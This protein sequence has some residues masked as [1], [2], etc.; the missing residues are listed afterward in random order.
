[1]SKRNFL[2]IIIFALLLIHVY[3]FLNGIGYSKNINEIEKYKK[4]YSVKS[5]RLLEDTFEVTF[6]YEKEYVTIEGVSFYKIKKTAKNKII[7]F[8]NDVEKP[9]L[10][11]ISQSSNLYTIDFIFSQN[12][13]VIK[14]SEW[15]KSNRLIYG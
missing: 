7:N 4:A 12:E 11:I 15:L 2:L 14:F 6:L 13:Q 1:M 3:F 8:F 10:L 9:K 5:I